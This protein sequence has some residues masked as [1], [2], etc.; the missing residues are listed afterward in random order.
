MQSVCRAA[1]LGAACLPLHLEQKYE[2]SPLNDNVIFSGAS[3]GAKFAVSR[4]ALHRICSALSASRGLT[5]VPTRRR[6]TPRQLVSANILA[7]ESVRSLC[8]RQSKLGR[9]QRRVSHFAAKISAAKSE[10]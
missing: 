9:R 5:G 3:G 10:R 4:F 8:D 6:S 1:A 7:A 2:H